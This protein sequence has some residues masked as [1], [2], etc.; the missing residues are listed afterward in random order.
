MDYFNGRTSG[1]PQKE[2]EDLR[3]ISSNFQRKSVTLRQ[4]CTY[5]PNNF[6]TSFENQFKPHPRAW[7]TK[8]PQVAKIAVKVLKFS[9]L[10][11]IMA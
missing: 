1:K 5:F 2:L 11:N 8:I 7:G 9:Y 3:P 4:T 6:F 10:Q